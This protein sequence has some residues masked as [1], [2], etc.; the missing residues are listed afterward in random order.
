MG[1]TKSKPLYREVREH[2]K[3]ID[4]KLRA[5][6]KRLNKGGVYLIHDDSSSFFWDSAFI[7]RWKGWVMIFTEHHGFHIYDL[8]EVPYVVAVPRNKEYA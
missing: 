7:Q 5:D 3:A 8:S 6:D 4:A 2:A 1:T